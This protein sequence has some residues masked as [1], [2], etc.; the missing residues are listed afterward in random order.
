MT[1]FEADGLLRFGV[2][3]QARAVLPP[4]REQIYVLGPVVLRAE[5]DRARGRLI[6]PGLDA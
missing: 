1:T 4:R 6:G 3:V 2:L 5:L